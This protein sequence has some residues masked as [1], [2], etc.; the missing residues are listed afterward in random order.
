MSLIDELLKEKESLKNRIAAIELLL[1]SYG[2]NNVTNHGTGQINFKPHEEKNSFPKKARRDKQVLWIFKNSLNSAA[3]L[4]TI[5]KKYE[6][7]SGTENKI[8][9]IARRLKKD[10]KLVVVKYN[11]QNRSSFW[12]LP[13]WIDGKDF[14]DEYRPN[15]N[16]LPLDIEDTEVVTGEL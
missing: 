12:G 1:D 16:M 5:Q 14:I 9:N 2:Y 11:K 3:K 13:E 6:E 10:G 8:S 15:E 4:N 7:L